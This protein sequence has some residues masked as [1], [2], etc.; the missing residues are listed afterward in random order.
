VNFG[1]GLILGTQPRPTWWPA[2]SASTRPSP[3]GHWTQHGC[4]SDVRAISNEEMASI[5]QRELTDD[6]T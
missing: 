6:A 3:R 4:T 1:R 2:T 5:L